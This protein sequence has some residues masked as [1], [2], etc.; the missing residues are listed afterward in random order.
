MILVQS[1]VYITNLEHFL[2]Q[3][4]NISALPISLSTTPHLPQCQ[5]TTN[6]LSSADFSYS[7]HFTCGISQFVILCDWIFS[8]K[9]IFFKAHPCC[10]M[11]ED[12]VFFIAKQYSVMQ[13][14]H[15]YLSFHRL[16]GTFFPHFLA[17]L[18][19]MTIHEEVFAR[20][21]VFSSLGSLYLA[22][23]FLGQIV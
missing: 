22:V 16:I 3:P 2:Y 13:A 6:L 8:L 12:F 11:Y 23:K 21:Y 19:N 9:I 7:G 15:I 18:N 10:N 14:Y 5:A 20:P 4:P 17:T 1:C